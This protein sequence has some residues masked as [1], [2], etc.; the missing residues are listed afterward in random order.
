MVLVGGGGTGRWHLAFAADHTHVCPLLSHIRVP[1]YLPHLPTPPTSLGTRFGTPSRVCT[2]HDCAGWVNTLSGDNSLTF[3]SSDPGSNN[4]PSPGLDSSGHRHTTM[5][6]HGAWL[7]ALERAVNATG[8]EASD[9]R[10]KGACRQGASNAREHP[11]LTQRSPPG[12]GALVYCVE[13]V[14]GNSR[15]LIEAV[16]HAPWRGVLEVIDAAVVGPEGEAMPGG[17]G[18]GDH[19]QNAHRPRY[20]ALPNFTKFGIETMGIKDEV[21]TKAVQAAKAEA[22]KA[23]ATT[24]RER[25]RAAAAAVAAQQ[26]REHSVLVRALT[27][28]RLVEE[29]MRGI[30]PSILTTDTE[31]HDAPVI[32]IT[33]KTKF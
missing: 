27:I 29:Y 4:S 31:G 2:G 21:P 26:R 7:D 25:G 22:A 30:V 12:D 17:A 19:D 28:D 6:D 11:K 16:K 14:P 5:C 8:G 32:H 9:A 20:V 24:K 18:A 13:P 3:D 1:T 23:K 15:V 33:E 10:A